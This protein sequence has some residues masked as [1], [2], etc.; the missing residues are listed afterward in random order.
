MTGPPSTEIF[1][2]ADPDRNA[3]HRPSG[4]KVG[5]SA[6]VTPA[7]TRGASESSDRSA[8]ALVPS[9]LVRYTMLRPSGEMSRLPSTEET[10][11]GEAKAKRTGPDN[12]CGSLFIE[13]HA[14][15]PVAATASA[16]AAT[17]MGS[18]SREPSVRADAVASAARW[19]R[20][21]DGRVRA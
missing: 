17:T 15:N 12:T 13:L 14:A 16:T 21:V 2:K 4:E 9:T 18:R 20:L 10:S 11:S 5:L 3:T 8:S 7:S 19:L 6:A 1:F